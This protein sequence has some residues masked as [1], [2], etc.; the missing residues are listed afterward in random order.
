MTDD[1]HEDHNGSNSVTVS[2]FYRVVFTC[3]INSLIGNYTE[4][5]SIGVIQTRTLKNPKTKKIQLI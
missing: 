1:T 5:T 2:T 3:S 4:S